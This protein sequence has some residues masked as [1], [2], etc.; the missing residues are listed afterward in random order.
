MPHMCASPSRRVNNAAHAF[1]RAEPS[2]PE[3]GGC[4]AHLEH[5][6]LLVVLDVEDALHTVDVVAAQVE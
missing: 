4:A 6:A 1:L 5:E 2:T 3:A